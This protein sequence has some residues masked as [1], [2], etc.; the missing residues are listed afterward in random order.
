MAMVARNLRKLAHDLGCV[1][2]VVHHTGKPSE[3]ARGRK[4][5]QLLR[6]SSVIHG[7]LSA[8][9]LYVNGAP[10]THKTSERDDCV[11]FRNEL[12]GEL[13]AARSLGT[14]SLELI[15][16]DDDHGEATSA[17]WRVTAGGTRP[18]SDSNMTTS[19]A[20]RAAAGAPLR[21]DVEL[22]RE[23]LAKIEA[24]EGPRSGRSLRSRPDRPADPNTGRPIGE[25]RVLAALQVLRADPG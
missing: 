14:I 9:A 17:S 20:P 11:V 10:S 22:V 4:G 5:G 18:G 25:H 16:E 24:Q 21:S 3:G 6:G 13:K 19:N 23:W 7:A 15:I 2:L 1:V 8:G 12:E